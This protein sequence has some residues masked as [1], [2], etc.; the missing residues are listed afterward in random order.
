MVN[1]EQLN[2]KYSRIDDDVKRFMKTGEDFYRW[3]VTPDMT[4]DVFELLAE[5]ERL[6][7]TIVVAEHRINNMNASPVGTIASCEYVTINY[8]EIIS[9]RNGLK[10]T[11]K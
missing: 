2:V 11:I 7:K 5:V 8:N 3:T 4:K 9:I 6:R 10:E 1:T